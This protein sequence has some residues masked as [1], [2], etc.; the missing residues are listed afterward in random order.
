MKNKI[1]NELTEENKILEKELVELKKHQNNLNDQ[2]KNIQKARAY[3]LWQ[4]I[5]EVKKSFLNK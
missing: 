2:M 4:K 3:K 1:L 5:N